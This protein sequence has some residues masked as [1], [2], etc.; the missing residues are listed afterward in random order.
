MVAQNNL[1]PFDYEKK[2]MMAM[3]AI[4]T[5][6]SSSDYRVPTSAWAGYGLSQTVSMMQSEKEQNLVSEKEYE[7]VE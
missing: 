4:Q 7:I 2:K 6:P 1:T 3:K 5:K